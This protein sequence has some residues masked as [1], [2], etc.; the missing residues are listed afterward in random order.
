MIIYFFPLIYNLALIGYLKLFGIGWINYSLL[1]K[2]I[3]LNLFFGFLLTCSLLW[4]AVLSGLAIFK[5]FNF[6]YFQGYY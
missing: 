2:G 5:I 4:L 1:E 6:N 3:V